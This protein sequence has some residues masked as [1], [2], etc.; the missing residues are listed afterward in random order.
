MFISNFQD[1]SCFNSRY[2]ND[3]HGLLLE[4]YFSYYFPLL[5]ASIRYLCLIKVGALYLRF[6]GEF[7]ECFFPFGDFCVER[8]EFDQHS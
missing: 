3:H 6:K 2:F 1:L 4:F 7:F 8:V 5:V